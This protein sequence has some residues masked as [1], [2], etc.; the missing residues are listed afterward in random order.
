ML[1]HLSL[2]SCAVGD[3]GAQHIASSLQRQQGMYTC[4]YLYIY[5]ICYIYMYI[6]ILYI[7]IFIYVYMYIYIIYTGAQHIASSLQRQQGMYMYMY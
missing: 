1:S 7:H 4:I 2:N 3:T 5:I 6:Y